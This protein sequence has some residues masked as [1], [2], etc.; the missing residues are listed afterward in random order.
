MKIARVKFNNKIFYTAFNEENKCLQIINGDIFN[1]N[2][3]LLN[4][5]LDIKQ[6]EFLLP[7]EPSKIITLGYNYKD[8]VGERNEY[9]EPIIFLKPPS[10]L[11]LD[12]ETIKIPFNI[13]VWTEVELAIIVKKKAKFIEISTAKDFI[14]GYTITNDVTMQNIKNRDHHLARS[15]GLDTFCPIGKYI[16]KD[17][18]TSDLKLVNKINEKI[19]QLSTT[20]NR[21]LND[22]QVVSLVSK[23]ITLYPGDL[24]LTG[25][26]ANAENSV[27]SNGDVVELFIEKIGSLKNY[28]KFLEYEV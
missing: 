5:F 21:I 10:S 1:D 28:V 13:K 26:P 14:L 6:V 4:E 17:I 7:I 27:I 25:T 23:F 3:I 24:I 18:D 19:C 12:G 15:K 16:I 8:L 20:K 11:I 22:F 9:D 2:I